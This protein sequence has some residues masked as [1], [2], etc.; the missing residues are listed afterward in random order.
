MVF[1]LFNRN[2]DGCVCW[3]DMR[4]KDVLFVMLVGEDPISSLCFKP[5]D[6][7]FILYVMV[8]FFV[9]NINLFKILHTIRHGGL[10]NMRSVFLHLAALLDNGLLRQN[11][12]LYPQRWSGYNL[13]DKKHHVYN[14]DINQTRE[15]IVAIILHYIPSGLPYWL[16]NSPLIQGWSLLPVTCLTT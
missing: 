5:G 13:L 1:Y 14:N 9:S 4:C 12:T 3:F 11:V 15:M 7:V 6:F 8:N 10:L 2:Q 16:H